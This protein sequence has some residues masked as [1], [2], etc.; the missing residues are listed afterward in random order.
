MVVLGV[1]IGLIIAGAGILFVAT[2]MAL[3]KHGRVR[4][5]QAWFMGVIASAI[6]M[7]AIFMAIQP[8]SFSH[9]VYGLAIGAIIGAIS[10]IFIR[11]PTSR[12]YIH[13]RYGSAP[14]FPQWRTASAGGL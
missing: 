13:S 8:F 6:V 12:R 7:S 4:R 11:L 2:G 3:S 14:Q 1:L 5:W 10:G 9:I